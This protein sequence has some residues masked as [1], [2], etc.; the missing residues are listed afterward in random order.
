MQPINRLANT[1]HNVTSDQTDVVNLNSRIDKNRPFLEDLKASQPFQDLLVL[2]RQAAVPEQ[3]LLE[4]LTGKISLEECL[5]EKN[6][7][8]TLL[9]K[10]NDKLEVRWFGSHFLSETLAT[11][12]SAI[13]KQGYFESAEKS[14]S[15][16]L[17]LMSSLKRDDKSRS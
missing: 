15:K 2:M 11:T 8:T 17:I 13:F 14:H 4:F 7:M 1:N 16:M 12:L 3:R 9:V 10:T 6:W 5:G